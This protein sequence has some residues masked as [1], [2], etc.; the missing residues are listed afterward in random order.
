MTAYDLV[1]AALKRVSGLN[2]FGQIIKR[3]VTLVKFTGGAMPDIGGTM[4]YMIIGENAVLSET[5]KADL[6]KAK[7]L[8]RSENDPKDIYIE[9][10]W[11]F[12]E[13]DGKWRRNISDNEARIDTTSLTPDGDYNILVPK[14]FSTEDVK[15]LFVNPQNL[16][17]ANY[18]GRLFHVLNHSLLFEKYPRLKGLP[19]LYWIKPDY[20]APQRG[21]QYYF[22]PNK[23]GG[24]IVMYGS[25]E[26]GTDISILLHEIQ[27]AI[28]RIEGFS[29]GGNQTLARFVASVGGQS[30]RKVFTGINSVKS[31]L[32]PKMKTGV[33]NILKPLIDGQVPTNETSDYLTLL[34]E[35]FDTYEIY[36][37]SG[38]EIIYYLMMYA[39]IVANDF[40]NPITDALS[41]PELVGEHLYTVT[42]LIT[43]AL[44]AVS[45]VRREYMDKGLREKDIDRI[46]FETYQNLYGETESRSVQASRLVCSEFRNYFYLTEWESRP[47]SEIV[48]IDNMDKIVNEGQIKGAC[49]EKGGD[50][51][52]HFKRGGECTPFVHELG[53]IVYDFMTKNGYEDRIKERFAEIH[54]FHDIEEYFVNR[55]VGYMAD[56]MQNTKFHQEVIM[57]PSY[58]VSEA[59]MNAIFDSFFIV[60][61]DET[62]YSKHF[63]FL[64]YLLQE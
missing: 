26:W 36:E 34:K 25:Y 30:I 23:N 39:G 40:N 5:E 27:H 56:L 63:S 18:T 12:L 50:Y 21:H 51:V 20:T 55:F 3:V 37:E 44:Y 1:A 64:S 17:A 15:Q 38:D 46:L 42:N 33:Y 52:M 22:N 29:Q 6:N 54:T 24:F 14:D 7:S 48:V 2:L 62:M 43:E 61:M 11:F 32:Q 58:G 45:N 16:Y 59:G 31:I 4:R 60:P 13:N 53:H 41:E 47:L 10:G 19:L 35:L 9:T 49:E 8:L 28:Q 57:K